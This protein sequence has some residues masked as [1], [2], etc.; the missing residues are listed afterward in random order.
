MT[1][2][3]G[4]EY[5]RLLATLPINVCSRVLRNSR[6]RVERDNEYAIRVEKISS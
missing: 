4:A 2:A 1:A 6:L 5:L 3:M